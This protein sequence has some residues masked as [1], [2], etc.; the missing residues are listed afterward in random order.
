MDNNLI[1]LNDDTIIPNKYPDIWEK[2]PSEVKRLLYFTDEIP[3][4]DLDKIGVKMTFTLTEGVK[5]EKL[6][7]K[8]DPSTIYFPLPIAI[9]MNIGKV[10]PPER[11]PKYYQLTLE[12]KYVYLNWLQDID[13]PIP[14]GYR[15]LLLAGL[16]RQL[17]IG[18]FDA[19]WD[20]I[21]RLR[22]AV[23]LRTADGFYTQDYMFIN[24]SENT[25]FT[26]CL[27][28]NRTDLFSKMKYLYNND[29]WTDEQLLIK[30]YDHEPIDANETI[31]ILYNQGVNSLYFGKAPEIYAEE[32]A[33]IFLEKTGRSFILPED[34]MN[35]K[36]CRKPYII[37]GFHNSSFPFELRSIKNINI[38]DP[39]DIITFLKNIH[40][41]CHEKTKIRLRKIRSKRR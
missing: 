29:W 41:E 3:P 22:K 33:K 24:N 31:K 26:A 21:L 15:H 5:T 8:N 39:D 7:T 14:E 17:L 38:P 30:Y 23:L 11:Y 19:A 6:G 37:L 32:M 36:K 40:P 2:I 18:D 16:E 12:Q 20:M 10:P 34:Y 28:F 27:V 9:P 25:L 4:E 1:Q 13:Q 35:E